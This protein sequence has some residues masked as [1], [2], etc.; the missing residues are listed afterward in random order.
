LHDVERNAGGFGESRATSDG[1]NGL[2]VAKA[3]TKKITEFAVLSAEA[4][5]GLIGLEAPHTS[6]PPLDAAMV[7]LEPIVQV[8]ARP[9][10]DRPPQ[11]HADR[12]GVGSVAVCRHPVRPKARGRLCRTEEG[13]GCRHVAMLAEHGIDQVPVSIDSAIQV[14]PGDSV[15]GRTPRTR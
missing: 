3:A 14:G 1:G 6:D 15:G 8:S 4:T 12:P 2:V 9:V 7:L 11:R 5:G 13:L 10:P